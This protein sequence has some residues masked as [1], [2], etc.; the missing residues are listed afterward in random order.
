MGGAKN[1]EKVREICKSSHSPN[2]RIVV[3]FALNFLQI[4]I[5]TCTKPLSSRY[6]LHS[7]RLS[8]LNFWPQYFTRNVFP[9]IY[10]VRMTNP[11]RGY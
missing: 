2:K 8:R 11:Q 9:K 1:C 4:K 7:K 3:S 5:F 10:F 6:F